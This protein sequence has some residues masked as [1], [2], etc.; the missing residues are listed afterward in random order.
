MKLV[1][2]DWL[3]SNASSGWLTKEQLENAARPMFCRSVGW[4]FDKTK[5]C[6]VIVP[7]LAMNG[8]SDVEFGRGDLSIPNKAILKTVVLRKV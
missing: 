5:D 3:D 8:A 6:T 7:H 4:L 1:L 2:I